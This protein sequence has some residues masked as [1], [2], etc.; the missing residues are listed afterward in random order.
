MFRDP[1][2]DDRADADCCG[3]PGPAAAPSAKDEDCCAPAPT[4]SVGQV[5][6][7]CCQADPDMP[8]GCCRMTAE[9]VSVHYG[10]KRV[11]DDVSLAMAPGRITAIIGP[12]GCGKSTFLS[13]LNRMSD[14]T[15]GC[16]V[17]GD[18]R[19]EGESIF[20]PTVDLISLRRRVGMIFQKP[21]PFPL[22]IRKN[23]HLPLREMGIKDRTRLDEI[24]ERVIRSVGLW[25]EVADRL[26]KSAHA[27]S[28]GQQQRLCIAR[29]IALDPD[30]LLFDEPCSALDP[31]SSAVVEE[32]IASL[33]RQYTVVIVTHNMA[34]AR[35]IAESVA[36][37]WVKDGSGRIIESGDLE[38]VF[39]GSTNPIVQDYIRGGR[40]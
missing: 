34:Q 6:D 29:A 25:D 21:N 30:V 27:L 15:Q 4:A 19:L 17:T 11:L 23:I 22:S 1:K 20:A 2:N 9:N 33:R 16:T 26:D 3:A 38:E 7:D 10:K 35:R 24:T 39:E 5:A 32:L 40:G 28:G 12:S 37:F 14:L 13:T 31:I 36:V 18:V 8:P